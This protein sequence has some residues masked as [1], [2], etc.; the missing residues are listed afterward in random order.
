MNRRKLIGLVWVLAVSLAHAQQNSAQRVRAFATLPNWTG[1]WETD[2]AA[3]LNSHDFSGLKPDPASAAVAAYSDEPGGSRFFPLMK[4]TAKPPYNP[5]WEQ[6][7]QRA[8]T[9]LKNAGGHSKTSAAAKTCTQ[10]G[11][12]YVMDSP[13]DEFG[14]FQVMV[15]PEETLFLFQSGAVRHIFTDGRPHPAK[16]DLWPTSMGDS[17]GHWEGATL[18]IDTIERQPGPIV[19]AGPFTPVLI[20]AP[21]VVADLSEQAHFVE[22]VRIVGND[23][24]QDDLTIE[25]PQRLTRPWH[26]SM[27]FKRVVGVDRMILS[28]CEH[29]RDVVV[30][31]KL[32]IAP[33]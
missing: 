7:Y 25:D 22:R 23:A 4:L 16:A 28:S 20:L 10:L 33:P 32:S 3:A 14:L 12:P 21:G 15:T 17:I 11:F 19:P 9:K 30:S 1:Y 6:K 2:L 18:V 8:L 27:H 31:G 26:I 29:D 13:A 24:L 5:Q